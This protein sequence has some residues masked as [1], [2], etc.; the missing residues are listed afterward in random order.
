MFNFPE[1]T[2]LM[3]VLLFDRFVGRRMHE[4]KKLKG[5]PALSPS[6]HPASSTGAVPSW[7]KSGETAGAKGQGYVRGG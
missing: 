7:I 1:E 2:N 3:V 6:T 5:L 4:T